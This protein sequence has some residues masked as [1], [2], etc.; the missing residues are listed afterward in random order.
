MYFWFQLFTAA[1]SPIL[2][3][4]ILEGIT[5]LLE[6]DESA[7]SISGFTNLLHYQ[8]TTMDY[9]RYILKPCWA[10]NERPWNIS[11]YSTYL[12]SLQINIAMINT[13]YMLT[14]GYS[15]HVDRSIH[16]LAHCGLVALAEVMACCLRAPSHSLNQWWLPIRF[17]DIN[18][19]SISQRVSKLL[20]CTT[21]VWTTY[22]E[23]LSIR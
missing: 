22:S 5:K 2:W 18:L 16:L 7:I 17:C 15:R 1:T 19:R 3:P 14:N 23:Q 20:F 6:I 10:L 11:H 9:L 12:V 21:S 8:G 13:S 4:I